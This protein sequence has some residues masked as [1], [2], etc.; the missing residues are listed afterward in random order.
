[1]PNEDLVLIGEGG[2]YGDVPGGGWGGGP[3]VPW[4]GGNWW[5]GGGGGGGYRGGGGFIPTFQGGAAQPWGGLGPQGDYGGMFGQR[6]R[7]MM[8]GGARTAFTVG[9]GG[10][11]VQGGGR[12]AGPMQAGP[13]G[14]PAGSPGGLYQWAQGQAAAAGGGGGGGGPFENGALGPIGALVQNAYLGGDPNKG[15]AFSMAPPQYIM[16]AIRSRGIA[17]AG[18]QER[19]ARLGLQ[20]RG[21]ADPST[22]GFQALMSQLGGQDRTAKSLSDAN[23]ALSQQQQQNYWD[24]LRQLLAA[25]VSTNQTEISGRWGQANQPSPWGQ[26]AQGGGALLGSLF[27]KGG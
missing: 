15:G 6:R 2:K 12:M 25:Q 11:M 18:A 7:M 1:M 20:S 16:D 13:F 19:A 9:G 4:G 24:M 3:N 21:D 27:G 23:L 5:G 22:Y 26:V 8:G 17:D 10:G 14:G